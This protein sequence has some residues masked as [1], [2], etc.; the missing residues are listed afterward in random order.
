VIAAGDPIG[1][2]PTAHDDLGRLGRA[3]GAAF[4]RIT[5]R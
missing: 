5:G 4:R 3:L 2:L 1:D